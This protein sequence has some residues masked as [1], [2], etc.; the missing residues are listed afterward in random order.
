[1][2]EDYLDGEIQEL[3]VCHI[4]S[5]FEVVKRECG[6]DDGYLRIKCMVSNGDILE[7]A[8]YIRIIKNMVHL[9]TYSF[10][11]QVATGKLLRR[12]DNVKH[13]KNVAT[14]PYHLHLSDDEVI[15]SEPMNLKKV[16]AEI[17]KV[18]QI[19]K[20]EEKR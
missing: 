17:G 1:M 14:Y 3:V 16:L 11:W 19:Q 7:F 20:S 4:I 8:E 5:S 6:E 13:H 12:W 2:I 18:L 9:E 10:H 15:D